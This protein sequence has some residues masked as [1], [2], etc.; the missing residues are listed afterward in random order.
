MKLFFVMVCV[1]ALFWSSNTVAG[2]CDFI[3]YNRCFSCD[4]PLAFSVGSDESCAYLCPN[5]T[6]NYEGSGSSWPAYNC[7][8]KECPPEYPYPALN[9]SCFASIEEAQENYFK[10]NTDDMYVPE[11][12]DVDYDT[13]ETRKCPP[14]EP[15]KNWDGGC[16]SCDEKLIVQLETH[17]NLEKDCEDIC[18]NRTILYRIGGNVPSVP[19]CPPDKPLMDR[20]GVCYPCDVPI[21]IGLDLNERLCTQACPG[22]RVMFYGYCRL[23]NE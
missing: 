20:E 11:V 3:Q 17:C 2:N 21:R 4:D 16:Y 22:Q 8:L 23:I 6:V 10:Q 5:R 15:L 12:H 7:A 1:F 9:G 18:P 13:A 19:N 14:D